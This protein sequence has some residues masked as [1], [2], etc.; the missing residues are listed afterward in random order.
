MPLTNI[1]EKVNRP[2][3]GRS[4]TTQFSDVEILSDSEDSYFYEQKLVTHPAPNK[5]LHQ[6]LLV[7]VP[8]I[9]QEP[10]PA[11]QGSR[12]DRNQNLRKEKLLEARLNCNS[13]QTMP[14]ERQILEA[15]NQDL[16]SAK[17]VP[18][19]AS[20]TNQ[21]SQVGQITSAETPSLLVA[22]PPTSQ[23]PE[24][25]NQGS[26]PKED[27][28]QKDKILEAS[29]KENSVQTMPHERKRLGAVNLDLISAETAPSAASPPNQISKGGQGQITSTTPPAEEE[30]N[31]QMTMKNTTEDNTNT[32]VKLVAI[33]ALSSK[34]I[35]R[36]LEAPSQLLLQLF[37]DEGAKISN[38]L[39]EDGSHQQGHFSPAAVT[40]A[41]PTPES[42]PP[43]SKIGKLL[44]ISP[45]YDNLDNE[46]ST[47]ANLSTSDQSCSTTEKQTM[48]RRYDSNHKD[49]SYSD[50]ELDN[51][52]KAPRQGR[53]SKTVDPRS[54]HEDL[55]EQ[56]SSTPI[57]VGK[58]TEYKNQHQDETTTKKRTVKRKRE[59]KHEDKKYSDE[60]LN[61]TLQPSRRSETVNPRAR[62]EVPNKQNHRRSSKTVRFQEDEKYNTQR[63]DETDQFYRNGD[64]KSSLSNNPR[65]LPQHDLLWELEEQRA[66]AQR[67]YDQRQMQIKNDYDSRDYRH[68]SKRPHVTYEPS[69][70]KVRVSSPRAAPPREV[71]E[72]CQSGAK[73]SESI[74][75][76][77]AK[78]KEFAKKYPQ[79]SIAEY[80]ELMALKLDP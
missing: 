35:Q 39:P 58:D 1:I 9:S 33:I 38:Q 48:T 53:R 11:N 54:S 4:P 73:G 47:S 25:A 16:I 50:E 19:A 79:I 51:K 29:L 63:Y 71:R 57:R 72:T 40:T 18:L 13:V 21:I 44:Q 31:V 75:V 43:A 28:K 2:A 17:T 7:A 55:D 45:Q 10:K 26:N 23:E 64:Q 20:P 36:T 77:Y 74:E 42:S 34:E 15:V 65:D 24:P 3:R 69:K 52:K 66:Q 56:R 30:G 14:H 61:K 68:G 8:P 76:F 27:Q 67:R 41:A 46:T 60:G 37:L 59:S 62:H 70:T 80:K 49:D 78:Y 12:P 6:N 32:M 22:V 5:L